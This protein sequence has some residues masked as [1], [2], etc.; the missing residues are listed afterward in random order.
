M[1][2]ATALG[3]DVHQKQNINRLK[4]KSMSR[5]LIIIPFVERNLDQQFWDQHFLEL[6]SMGFWDTNLTQQ[7]LSELSQ[8]AAMV[9]AT[10]NS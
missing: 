9:P 8:A 5:F 2:E 7:Q 1:G 10:L 6:R 3:I 4:D